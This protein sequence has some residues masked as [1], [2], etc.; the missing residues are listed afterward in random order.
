MINLWIRHFIISIVHTRWRRMREVKDSQLLV[1][2]I[3][4]Q[5]KLSESPTQMLNPFLDFFRVL[6]F[7]P[8][9]M[10]QPQNQGINIFQTLSSQGKGYCDIKG[11]LLAWES[12]HLSATLRL[13]KNTSDSTSQ[14][15]KCV[16][17]LGI[18][19]SLWLPHLMYPWGIIVSFT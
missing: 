14:T 16:S 1:L 3:I 18:S 4:L 10:G 17:L 5:H 13:E 6:F 8:P 7:S 19:C 2:E 12:F 15:G 11:P 9:W